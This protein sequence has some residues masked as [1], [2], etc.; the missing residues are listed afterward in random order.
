[1]TNEYAWLR[2]YPEG[3]DWHQEVPVGTLPSLL[4]H[5]ESRFPDNIALD[6]KGKLYSY[7]ELGEK[8]RR[9]AHGLQKLGV[10]KGT[11][12]GLFL[13]NCPQF[14]I[15]YY[16][17]LKA[18]GIVVNYNPLYSKTELAHQIEDSET[19]IMVTLDI[20][21]LYPKLKPFI[22]QH[23]LRHVIVGDLMSVLPFAKSTLYRLL[24]ASDRSVIAQDAHHSNFVEVMDTT[25]I[26]NAP[27]IDATE[28]IAVLQYTG[29]TTGTPKGVMLTHANLT[30]NTHMCASWFVKAV[31]GE[32]T[33]M[34]VL[35]FFHVFAMTVIMNF[36]ISIGARIMMHPRF[37]MK[38]LLADITKKK[39]SLMPGVP[40][41]FTAICN[42]P[43]IKKYDLT[44]L[45]MCIS[46]GA[47]LPTEIKQRFER[48][49][50]CK[51]VEG[52][53]LSESSPV[54][55]CNP[56]YAENKAGSI[57]I[58]FPNTILEIVDKD[59]GER[60]LP[61]GE[62]GEIC[63]RGSQ[64]M[65]GYWKN[66]E[67]TASTIKHGRLY[68]G[69]IGYMDEQGYFFIVDRKKEMILSGGYNIYPRHIEEVLYTH[70]D[71]LE[72]AVIGIPEEL[73]GEVPK[74]FIVLKDGKDPDEV[75]MRAFLKDSLSAY[76]VPAE[77]AFIDEL[78]KSMIGK[79]LKKELK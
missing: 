3:I 8:V 15:A 56:L 36:G 42:E 61:Q 49:T 60:L 62:A 38:P 58:P 75:A 71:V 34:G 39:P 5:T 50:G 25:P 10:V 46:G 26:S 28:D 21:L 54:V 18:G 4:D 79:I 68:T 67:E 29:G 32:E 11:K 74:A 27:E 30:A 16:G 73:R 7:K 41:M 55:S 12:V 20:S 1:M 52:Y 40:T 45:Q 31:P 14:V 17:I 23:Q 77:I 48:V 64:V 47:G 33:I 43:D 70:E 19:E 35:P 72:C 9:F 37:E 66:E 24:K 44:S 78:P 63:I 69:D 6:F 13:P 2:H 65:R 59:D 76:A 22:G 57:G 51:L 53:G